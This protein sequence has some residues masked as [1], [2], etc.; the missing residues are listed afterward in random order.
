[1]TEVTRLADVTPAA[2]SAWS[3]AQPNARRSLI[4]C[5]AG[6]L[7]GLAVAGLG[8]FTAKGTRTA[9]VPAEDVAVVNQVPI[10]MS[11]YV[12]QLR[13]LY[14]VALGQATPVQKSKTLEDMIREELYVQ[15]GVE[16]GLQSDTV[17]V[18]QALVGAVEAQSAADAVMAQP[19]ET[20]LHA[21][22][23]RN[24]D[25]F[26]GEGMMQLAD[27]VLPRG[28]SAAAVAAAAAGLRAAGPNS[29]AADHIAPRSGLMG[30]GE[31][32]YFAARI[33]LGDRLYAAARGLKAGQISPP[34]AMPD[35][36]H[37]LVMTHNVTPVVPPF[38]EVR[39]KVLTAFV[40]A[41]TKLLTAAN[42]RFLRKRADIQIAKDYQ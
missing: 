25:S 13:A 31:E 23:D 17:E 38:T 20:E 32:F 10:L 9:S 3:L 22:Y 7:L 12:Q 18:R 15:R 29:P 26:A 24:R 11:D 35:G 37:L 27:H 39:D 14:D 16:L 42:E 5:A 41:Q 28:S 2:G 30:D 8:L 19:S 4:L 36:I 21:Y 33:H 1:M 6:A 34:V 40:A